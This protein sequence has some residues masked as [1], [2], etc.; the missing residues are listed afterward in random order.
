MLIE[1]VGL[2][3][4]F[5]GLA[6]LRDVSIRIGGKE[7]LGIIGPNGAGKTTLFDVLTGFTKPT[8]GQ[9]IYS[10]MEITDLPPDRIAHLGIYRTFQRVN[11]FRALTVT[12]NLVVGGHVKIRTRLWDDLFYTARCRRSERNVREKANDMVRF[13]GLERVFSQRAGTLSYGNQKLLSLGVAL[14][15]EPKILLLDEPAAGMNSAETNRLM[16]LVRKLKEE[17]LTIIVV[18]HDMKFIMDLCERIV[19]LHFGSII[20]EGTPGEVSQNEDVIRVY[21]GTKDRKNARN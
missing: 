10:G 11:V 13:L 5:G 18:E 14:M 4:Y 3:K 20:A 17:G 12:E 2:S 16:S 19:V 1:A 6:A 7:L 8:K 15:G 21:L 9:V